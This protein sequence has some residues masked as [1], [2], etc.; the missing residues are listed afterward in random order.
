MSLTPIQLEAFHRD[1]YILVPD[2]FDPDSMTAALAEM[3]R[4]FYGKPFAEWLNA[5]D[6]SSGSVR[7][8]FF[9]SDETGRSQF[10][11]GSDALDRLIEND[12]YLDAFA[13]CL[14]TQE[15][16]YCNAHLFMR[17]GP[18][19][20]R[21]SAN[22]WEGYHIDHGTN[23]FLPPSREVGKYDYVNCGVYLH[24][25]EDDAAPMRVIPGSHRQLPD[26][27]PRLIRDGIWQG[28][29]GI[30]DLRLA[31]EF[32]EP[33]ATTAK[34]GS[35]LFYS[36][37]LVHAAVPFENKRKQRAYW[38]LSMARGDNQAWSKFS[39]PWHYSDREHWLPFCTQTTPRV[40]SLFGWP[41][42]GHPF[43]TPETVALLETWWP[44]LDR[45]P[46]EAALK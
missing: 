16:S 30:T 6:G 25:V 18:T 8:G 2:L 11:T 3:E 15:M 12:A 38:T 34:A 7:D 10:P 4:I 9:S 44:G 32:A 13:D 43:Y 23:C 45:G 41:A 37:Y 22:L 31:P 39:N 21:H 27:L 20:R 36:S 17:S 26:L 29:A 35:A 42:P 24:D 14:G 33:V 19:D 40:R 46:Y 5:F 28:I 1:G